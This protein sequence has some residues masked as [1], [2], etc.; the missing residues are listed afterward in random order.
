[1]HIYL[2][3]MPIPLRPLL[4]TLLP[5]LAN[6]L[7]GATSLFHQTA[8][9]PH[10][11]CTALAHA[12]WS[13]LSYMLC[14]SLA[15][16][17]RRALWIFSAGNGWYAWCCMGANDPGGMVAFTVLHTVWLGC[18]Q[19][20]VGQQHGMGVSKTAPSAR[21]MHERADRWVAQHTAAAM[22]TAPSP[23]C[24]ICLSRIRHRQAGW[25][26]PYCPH[27][28]HRGCILRHVKQWLKDG[29]ECPLRCPSCRCVW[30][31]GDAPQS[32]QDGDLR[33]RFDLLFDDDD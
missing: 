5:F 3:V 29:V 12:N 31:R 30:E 25:T 2:T 17:D 13:L 8:A 18:W 27:P 28:Y 19:V 33:Y 9:S 10:W 26:S 6:W 14:F 24:I 4:R 20:A 11:T 21:V 23:F 32:P 7:F 1:V 15:P 16:M 22:A